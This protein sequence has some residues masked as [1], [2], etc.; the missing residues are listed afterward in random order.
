[1]LSETLRMYPSLPN[2][3]R[4]CTKPYTIPGTN[5]LIEKGTPVI[6][7]IYAIHRDQLYYS[8]P[9]RFDPER[10]TEYN[11]EK[12]PAYTYLP[13]GEGPR[14]CIGLRF[15][16]M[17]VKMGLAILVSRFQFDICEKSQ[18]PLIMDPKKFVMNTI[19][20]LWLKITPRT[21]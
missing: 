6:I 12:R 10:F 2:L 18:V 11:K 7:P 4:V 20:G 14:I 17:Q 9:D 16:L 5:V 3:I 15:G 1:M 21:Q 19:G 8:D 13:F